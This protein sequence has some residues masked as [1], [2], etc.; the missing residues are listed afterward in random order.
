MLKTSFSEIKKSKFNKGKYTIVEVIFLKIS[1]DN[2]NNTN[3]L[4]LAIKKIHLCLT[5]RIMTYCMTTIL[6]KNYVVGID[7]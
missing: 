1:E 4:L 5:N 2:I 6:H 7:K 3:N